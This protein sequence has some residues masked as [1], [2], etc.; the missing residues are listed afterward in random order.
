MAIELKDFRCKI[1]A[2]ADAVLE[3]E[4]Q[5]TGRDRS[6]IVRELV[7]EWAQ[8]RIDAATVMHRRLLAEGL[9]GIAGGTSG[10][11]GA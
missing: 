10:K 11:L 8:K 5:V 6:E 1:T 9:P 7:H 2:E 4:A 3:A